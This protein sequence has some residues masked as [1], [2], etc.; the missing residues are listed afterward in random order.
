MNSTEV[1]KSLERQF[2]RE[3]QHGARLLVYLMHWQLSAE[4]ANLKPEPWSRNGYIL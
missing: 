1:K 2:A 4:K 3:L